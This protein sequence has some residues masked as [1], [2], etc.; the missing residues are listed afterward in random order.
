MLVILILYILGKLLIRGTFDIIG[1]AF[2]GITSL[3][4]FFAHI[5]LKFERETKGVNTNTIKFI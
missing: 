3:S 2:L 1:V 5:S 4:M